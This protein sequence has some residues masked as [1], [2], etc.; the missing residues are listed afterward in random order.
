[1]QQLGNINITVIIENVI[2][3][4]KFQHL[5]RCLSVDDIVVYYLIVRQSTVINTDAA[6]FHISSCRIY[7]NSFSNGLHEV[8]RGI[9]DISLFPT[10]IDIQ[11]HEPVFG[12]FPDNQCKLDIHV[13]GEDFLDTNRSLLL[14]SILV[15]IGDRRTSEHACFICLYSESLTF[16]KATDDVSVIIDDIADFELHLNGLAACGRVL[17]FVE[18]LRANFNPCSI[19]QDKCI[20]NPSARLPVEAGESSLDTIILPSSGISFLI[21]TS[22]CEQFK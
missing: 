18:Y 17:S 6:K 2:F 12:A 4:V 15:T 16:I 7:G 8:V 21:A 19:L 22:G 1:M 5:L 14:V 13:A 11:F 20:V 3:I 10:A 9:I